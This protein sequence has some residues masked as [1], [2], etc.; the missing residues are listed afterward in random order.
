MEPKTQPLVKRPSLE[1]DEMKMAIA[2]ASMIA[3]FVLPAFAA[4]E[5]YVVQDVKTKKCTVVEKK[6]T[7]AKTLVN[8][9][10]TVYRTRPEAVSGMKSLEACRSN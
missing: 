2:V 1:E 4:D 9:A 7:D 5:Y 6:P 3:A 8:A 10:G